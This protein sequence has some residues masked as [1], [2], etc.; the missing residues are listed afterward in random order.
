MQQPHALL[1][2]QNMK[3]IQDL[4]KWKHVHPNAWIILALLSSLLT[5]YVYCNE[6]PIFPDLSHLMYINMNYLLFY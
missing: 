4:N 1:F 3:L 5:Q 2:I 6:C